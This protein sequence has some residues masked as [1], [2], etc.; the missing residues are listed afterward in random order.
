MNDRDTDV[1][2]K[3]LEVAVPLWI[4]VLYD[5]PK[6]DRLQRAAAVDRAIIDLTIERPGLVVESF[7]AL[8]EGLALLSFAPGGVTF[9]GRH[10]E[11]V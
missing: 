11:T 8:A 6:E 1:I 7:N 5:L 10:W 9:E 4:G 3:A 2:T